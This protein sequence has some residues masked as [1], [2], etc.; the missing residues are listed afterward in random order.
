MTDMNDDFDRLIER[1]GTDSVK[2][3]LLT[4]VFGS[5]DVLPMWVAD[6]DFEAP[7]LV[8]EAI[9][10]RAAHPV[11]GYTLRPERF[12]RAVAGWIGRRHG[13]NVDPGTIGFS[14]GVVPALNLCVMA[15]TEPGDRIVIQPPVY[16]PFFTA[17]SNHR[18]TIVHNQLVEHDGI[19]E[20]DFNRLEESFRE[21]V[22]MFILCHPHNPV[23]RAW[24]REELERL[25]GLCTRYGVLVISDEIHS[26]LLLNGN[27]HI[28]LASL[29]KEI[30]DLTITCVSPSKT[31]NLAGLHTSVVIITREDLKKEYDRILDMVH[32]GGGNIFGMVALEAAYTGGDAW[33]DQ[34][35]GYL[36]GNDRALREHFS[37][38]VPQLVIS[39]LEAT[40]LA[41]LDL[42]FLGM[43]DRAL[44]QFV[45]GRARLGLNDGP[46]FGPGG[47]QHQR[48]NIA[49]PRTVLMEGAGRL[50]DA[51]RSAG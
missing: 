18:R 16:F 24:R 39:P 51:I 45:I 48:M 43:D 49:T 9:L 17:V 12:Y 42:S 8:Q 6:M 30:A 4:P 3:D 19:Y 37:A 44:R 2:H 28:P 25:A 11:Y 46:M 35:I 34:L 27:K 1:K 36:E 40:Y 41:W 26:D 13:W 38:T 10:R 50:S 15:F 23:G 7:S 20:M 33:L 5:E 31:F 29:G 47:T 22:K 21:G 14:P 32:V